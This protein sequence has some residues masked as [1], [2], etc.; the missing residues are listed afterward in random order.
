M[1]KK[2][3]LIDKT[4]AL[5]EEYSPKELKSIISY[6]ENPIHQLIAK[7]LLLEDDSL[8]DPDHSSE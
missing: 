5:K 3:K 1:D 7:K 8:L 6:M 4:K 2:T